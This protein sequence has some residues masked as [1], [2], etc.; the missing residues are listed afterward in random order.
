MCNIP[1]FWRKFKTLCTHEIINH[2]FAYASHSIIL[3]AKLVSFWLLH[4]SKVSLMFNKQ[5]ELNYK[6]QRLFKINLEMFCKNNKRKIEKK[7]K[8]KKKRG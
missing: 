3:C 5:R 7:S 1:N 2:L 6:F 8:K 4:G